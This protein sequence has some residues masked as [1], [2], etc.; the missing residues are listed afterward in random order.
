MTTLRTRLL[1]CFA[2]VA[3][4]TGAVV[5]VPALTASADVV[6]PSGACTATG[7]WVGQGVTRS[8]T[9]Y[10]SSDVVTVPQKDKVNWQGHE[11][12]KPIGYFGPSRPIDGAVQ[13]TVPFGIKVTVWHWG[14]H[15]S[16]RYSNEGQESYH[17]PSVLVGIRMKLS[18][19]ERDNGKLICSGSVYVQVI[20]SRFKNPIGWA[21]LAG[22]VV[23]GAGLLAAGFRKTELAYDDI[24]P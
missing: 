2:A 4:L 17:V 7:H 23:F 13:V 9:S 11:E 22:I 6:T 18:G 21:G 20:G 14:G 3:V 15:N 12:G 10:V 24:N 16:Q 5:L 8:S 19:Y 1:A